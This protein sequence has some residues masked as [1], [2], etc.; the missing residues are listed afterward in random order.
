MQE[1]SHH[2][3]LFVILCLCSLERP[4]DFEATLD[5]NRL[6]LS[7]IVIVPYYIKRSQ[8]FPTFGFEFRKVQL[9]LLKDDAFRSVTK[10]W[11]ISV[12]NMI[13]VTFQSY[14]M[15]HE[16]L[17]ILYIIC[18]SMPGSPL[19]PEKRNKSKPKFSAF[20]TSLMGSLCH[21]CVV[22]LCTS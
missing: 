10:P 2:V 14:F 15:L 11:Y 3:Y 16:S 12:F 9:V 13:M 5:L 1:L 17:F 21:N 4:C 19:F 7:L 6:R 20:F 22:I 18:H 8:F